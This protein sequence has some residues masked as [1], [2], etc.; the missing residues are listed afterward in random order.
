M[1]GRLFNEMSWEEAGELAKTQDTWLI[2]EVISATTTLL[3]GEA[4]CGKSFL[5]SALIHSLTTGEDFLGAEVPQDREFS[6]AVCWTDDAGST[7]YHSRI[8]TL[9]VKP[10]ELTRFYRLPI[11]GSSA[12]WEQL[13]QLV[14]ERGHNVVV[15]D[16]MTQVLDGSFNQDEVI[17]RFFDG[18]RRFTHSGI[19]VIIVA[20]SSDKVNQAGKKSET[21]LGSSTITQNVRWRI[22]AKR[23]RK[24]NVTLKFMGNHAESREITTH[25]GTG[26][27]FEVIGEQSAHQLATNEDAIDKQRQASREALKDDLNA[28]AQGMSY[29]Q[30]GE[31]LKGKGKGDAGKKRIERNR[32]RQ[33]PNGSWAL[34]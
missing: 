22:F 7:E 11:M 28:R 29:R 12:Q 13:Y 33:C 27:R 25:H 4:K 17:R 26:A 8:S 15:I 30:A 3:Y 19:P 34:K 20:H 18:V 2:E 32:I 1:T 16:S 6:V 14:T 31:V 21:V 10:E 5:V 24:G 9:G 23:S